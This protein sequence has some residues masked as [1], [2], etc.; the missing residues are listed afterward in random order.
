[1]AAAISLVPW[2]MPHYAAPATVVMLALIIQGLRMLRQ[3]RPG[4]ANAIPAIC[5]AIVGVRIGM[6]LLPIPFV[7]TYPMTWATTWSPRLERQ[8]IAERLHLAGGRHLAIVR[9][10]PAHDPLKEYVFNAADI[11]QS[12]IVWA[13]DMGEQRNAKLVEYFNSRRVWLLE[14]DCQPPQITPYRAGK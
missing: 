14:P 10:G 4:L 3:W 5:V 1:M 12:E 6:A 11:D 2:F 8:A 13:H 7:L 9:Y